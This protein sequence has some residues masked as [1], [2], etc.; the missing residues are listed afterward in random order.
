MGGARRKA[1]AALV[2]LQLVAT[3]SRAQSGVDQY[4]PGQPTGFVSDFAGVI[5]AG[6]SA[7]MT[8]LIEG[9][10]DASQWLASVR[11]AA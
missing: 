10:I 3:A 4:V 9:R 6:S 11:R 1:I 8:D 2:L 5:D 7:H